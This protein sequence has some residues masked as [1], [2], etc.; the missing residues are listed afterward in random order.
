[1]GR[2]CKSRAGL[3]RSQPDQ[4]GL[5]EQ[6]LEKWRSIPT[7]VNKYKVF[8]SFDSKD[9]SRLWTDVASDRLNVAAVNRFV[10]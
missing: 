3:C 4:T 1:V 5:P 10:T 9:S 2:A 7:E 8:D 6:D